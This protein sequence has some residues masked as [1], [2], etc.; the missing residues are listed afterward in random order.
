[1]DTLLFWIVPVA[2]LLALLFAYHFYRQM[3]KESEGTTDMIRIAEAV[4]SGAS[5]YLK[6]QYRVVAYVFILLAIL[7]GIMALGFNLQNGWV[8]IAFLT[9]GFFSGLAGYLGMKTATHASARTANACKRSLNSGLKIA[10]RSGA[11]MGLVV[12]GLGLFDIS[13][14]YILLQ[15]VIPVDLL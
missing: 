7:L 6:Q 1:M 14:W 13:F 3:L 5:S 8:P 10:F 12:V 11:V 9:G 15:A 4:R 2:S